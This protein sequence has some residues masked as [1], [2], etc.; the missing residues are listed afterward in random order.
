MPGD[1]HPIEGRLVLPFYLDMLESAAI[2]RADERWDELI[3][4]GHGTSLS[5]VL[6]LLEFPDNWRPPVMGAW[7]SLKFGSDEVGEQILSAFERWT[8]APTAMPLAIAAATV[9]GP[10]AVEA[11]Q[12]F[13]RRSTTGTEEFVGAGVLAL[14]ATPPCTVHPR[15]VEEWDAMT[16]I[17]QRLRDALRGESN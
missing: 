6:F 2:N 9:V 14:G 11:L 1:L 12:D 3:E 13:C 8:M 4:A 10:D 17:A 15:A 16:R 7:F 5:D